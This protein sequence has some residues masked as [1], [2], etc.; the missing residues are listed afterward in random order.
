[1]TGAAGFIGSAVADALRAAE[2]DVVSVDVLIP[3][4]HDGPVRALSFQPRRLR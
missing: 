2:H 3:E 1:M 4:A